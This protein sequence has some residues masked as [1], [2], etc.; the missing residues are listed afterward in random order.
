M[1]G[2][3]KLNPEYKQWKASATTMNAEALPVVST[4]NDC[5]ELQ[6]VAPSCQI[7]NET[8]ETLDSIPQRLEG[9]L[10]PDTAL[11][12]LTNLLSKYEVPL[13]LLRKLMILSEFDVL[14][15]LVDDSGS[16][17]L[18]SDT[19]NAHD[20]QTQTRWQ[21]AASRLK[22]MMEILS[23]LPFQ[24][25]KIWFLNRPQ[26]LHFRRTNRDP[27]TLYQDMVAQIDQVFAEAPYGST[28]AFERL[29]QSFRNYPPQQTIARYFF[30]DGVPNGGKTAQKN[31]LA[32][33][34]TRP[35]PE[36]HPVTFL[37]CTSNDEE[38]LWMKEAEEAA[39]YCAECDDYEDEM[40]E[41]LADQGVAFPYTRGFW[42]IC[43]LVSA[44]FPDDLDALDE[45]VPFT[46]TTLDRLLGIDHTGESYKYYFECFVKAQ[47]NKKLEKK[48][49]FGL[50][51]K[52]KVDAL[53]KNQNWKPY[54]DEFVIAP[55]AHQIPVVREFREKLKKLASK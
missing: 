48:G 16:M 13:G 37:S 51:N 35:H 29:Q 20:G 44:C 47:A 8:Q 17:G 14:E 41:V 9:I 18:L 40:R 38:V 25:V 21:E 19:K 28:P 27:V 7:N 39:P 46:K 3:M 52:S 31:I 4:V 45:S 50:R 32:L 15:F 30:G 6:S 49:L 24:Q 55:V 26:T 23:Y 10:S 42:L 33:L 36:Q 12:Q 34:Q 22:E 2:V 11:T 43:A 54:Y 5:Q 53:K 1:N